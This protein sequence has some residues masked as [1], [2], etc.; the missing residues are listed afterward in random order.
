MEGNIETVNGI[1]PVSTESSGPL[2]IETMVLMLVAREGLKAKRNFKGRERTQITQN[3]HHENNN[4]VR[5][6]I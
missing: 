2:L 4:N 6:N 1:Q 5:M 3:M